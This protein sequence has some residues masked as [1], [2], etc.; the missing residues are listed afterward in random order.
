MNQNICYNCGGELTE[1]KGR[2]ICRYCGSYMPEHIST[3]EAILLTSASQKLRLADFFDAEQEFEDIIRRYP[4]N[5]QGYWGHMMAKYGIKY[6]EDYDGTRIPT[7]YAASIESV[8]DS[9]D[10]RMA[11]KYAD[12]E[13]KA[14]YRKHAEYIENVRIEWVEKASAEPPYDIFI[15]F[16]ASDIQNGIE[17]TKDSDEMR[18]LYFYLM[19]KGYRVFFSRESL[20][21]KTGEKYEP[22]IYGALSTAKI[23]LV[24][25]SKPE[26]INATWVKNEWT[27]FRKRMQSGEK[28]QGS[29]L[30]IYDGF[31]PKELP[32]ALSSLQCMDAGDKRRFYPDLLESIERILKKKDPPRA[33]VQ[34]SANEDLCEH[35]PMTI[36]GKAPTCTE[37]GRT[38]MII[39]VKCGVTLQKPEALP[40]TGHSFGE[41]YIAQKATC[42][43]GGF[44]ERVCHCG[45][46]E[47]RSFPSR[48]GHVP[49]EW[50]T[51][52][53]PAPGTE[54]LKA[55]K[56]AVCGACLEEQTIPALPDL[57]PSQ[58]LEY[59]ANES[60][61]TCTITSPGTCGSKSL[62]IPAEI[63]GYRV[64]GIDK[65]AFKKQSNLE[66]VFIPDS[67][68]SI[69]NDAF[70]DCT[71]LMSVNISCSVTEIGARAFSGCKNL[72][73]FEIPDSVTKIGNFAFDECTGLAKLNVP[74]SVTSIGLCA[75]DG[76]GMLS[77]SQ[78]NPSYRIIDGNLYSKDGKTLHRYAKQQS[79]R[80]FTVPDTVTTIDVHAFS[81]CKNLTS[82]SIPDSVTTLDMYAFFG[83]KNLASVSIPGSVTVIGAYAFLEC[84]NLTSVSIPNSVTAIREGAFARSGL[85]SVVIPD[86][87]V[88][89]GTYRG[90]APIDLVQALRYW[91]VFSGCA[92]LSRVTLGNSLKDIGSF[93]FSNCTSLRD[94]NIP[95]SVTTIGDAA[96]S[97]CA[98][99]SCLVIPDSVTKIGSFAFSCCRNLSSIG[100]PSTVT[101]LA[102][103]LFSQCEQLSDV[104]VPN[105]VK[106][107]GPCAFSGCT[108]LSRA[109]IPDSVTQIEIE[110]FKDCRKL[111]F[112]RYKGTKKQWEQVVCHRDWKKN[113]SVRK[114]KCTFGTLPLND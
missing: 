20:R 38:D 109:V 106:T 10:Y 95:D 24:Y 99:L 75:F 3:E 54:G 65:E 93:T 43:E 4:A 94:V 68:T 100:I 34:N 29:L 1:R 111:T 37:D 108:N 30:V 110:A 73:E 17:H 83:C 85:K 55:K 13:N 88:T 50:E 26:Y 44:H 102:D 104:V 101:A 76:V 5:A 31:D 84:E 107:I 28:R 112:L 35:E 2:R 105:S 66:S 33:T 97:N 63:N 16:K 19:S 52:K 77:V 64:T 91:G 51:V 8:F 81:D 47:T 89:L 41:W 57:R 72:A 113:S 21:E 23:M 82:V 60:N 80:S 6:E 22:Y 74:D 103:S 15:S 79:A 9:S 114:V 62:I 90:Y 18:E 86:S 61:K 58:G 56:C 59:A 70:C 49:G 69:G 39:C 40:A 48:G 32:S 71:S 87:V 7:C 92:Y 78:G 14:V 12:E 53:R 46:K 27:R 45:E 67:V 11:L 36:S 96:F 98:A 25:G 42:T